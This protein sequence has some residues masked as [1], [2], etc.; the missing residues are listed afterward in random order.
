MKEKIV[1]ISFT[2]DDYF[3]KNLISL[4]SLATL[5]LK[6]KYDLIIF[7]NGIAPI[8]RN[9]EF[10]YLMSLLSH[11]FN[12]NYVYDIGLANKTLV[13]KREYIYSRCYELGYDFVLSIDGDIVLK[14]IDLDI[15]FSIC[16]ND[17]S[18]GFLAFFISDIDGRNYSD[19][20]INPV[21]YPDGRTNKE[22]KFWEKTG[23]DLDVILRERKRKSILDLNPY[24]PIITKDGN[25]NYTLYDT[26]S[27]ALGCALFNLKKAHKREGVFK[28]FIEKQR[29]I[30]GLESPISFG[31]EAF[32][33]NKLLKMGLKGYVLPDH[34]IAYHLPNDRTLESR[35][36]YRS[37]DKFRRLLDN[38][39]EPEIF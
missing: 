17:K 37:E 1:I 12:V 11:N 25:K 20:D 22:G 27:L 16:L 32:L 19:H 13:E 9:Y 15:I 29:K 8:A 23:V 36:G 24:L 5:K 4:T 3:K 31:E 14:H 18:F 7:D 30:V 39:T 2:H 21:E 28:E 33:A 26:S 10:G 35:W 34:G 38:L 6:S